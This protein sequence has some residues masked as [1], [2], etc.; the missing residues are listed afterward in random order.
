M[1]VAYDENIYY[2]YVYP[3]PVVS[4]RRQDRTK[5]QEGAKPYSFS[6]HF[7]DK[8]K[9]IHSF[10]FSMGNCPIHFHEPCDS[11]VVKF[12]FSTKESGRRTLQSLNPL[13]PK[14]PK[15]FNI[16]TPLKIVIHGYGG[17]AVDSAIRNVTKA[18][19]D[20]G[21]NVIIVDW[22]NLAS[23]PCYFTAYLNT[24]HVG[25][26]IAI[27]AV[28]L[29][30]FGISPYLLHLIGFSLGAHIAGFAGANLKNTAGQSF[31]RITGL[32]PALPFFATL[33]ND[34]KLDPSDAK[35][36]DVV[37]TSAGTFGKLEPAGDVDFYMNGGSLQP[38]CLKRK[39]PPL[40]SH[41]MSGL[42]FAESIRNKGSFVGTECE[43]YT[44]YWLGGCASGKR[45]LMGEFANH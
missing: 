43:N 23:I 14:L 29:M 40:C 4:L 17:L 10:Q 3:H 26:C 32:D 31:G 24:W 41:V 20:V 5:I 6:I 36:V 45:A 33:S 44:D 27:L 28:S 39:Y 16:L 38:F 25:Q 9:I 15:A 13:K 12:L 42:Y 11:K 22:T 2:Y 35:F 7:S 18:Y 1:S 37:H 19:E 8:V 21:Y 30:R 34:W